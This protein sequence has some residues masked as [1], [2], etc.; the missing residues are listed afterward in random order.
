MEILATCSVH[1][2]ISLAH[3]VF[4]STE[5]QIAMFAR[6]KLD[7]RLAIAAPLSTQAQAD[8]ASARLYGKK[9]CVR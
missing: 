9:S 7:Q 4:M 5:R 8:A 6:L 2:N 1:F 3:K